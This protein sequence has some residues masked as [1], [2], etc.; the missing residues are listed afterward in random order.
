[1]SFL[2]VDVDLAKKSYYAATVQRT[3]S[4]SKLQ[5]SVSCD[6]AVED[7]GLAGLSAAIELTDRGYSV[8]V[9]E[10]KKVGWGAS[11]RNGGQALEALACDQ[12]TIEAQL[13]MIEAR[14]IWAM[15]SEA[16]ALIQERCHRFE[17]ECDWQSGYLSL[18]VNA[19]KANSVREWQHHIQ[20]EYPFKTQWTAQADLPGWNAS[21]P[22]HSGVFDTTSGHLN[23]LKYSLG[24]ARAAA[25]LGVKI[26]RHSTV[27]VL[28]QGE[29]VRLKTE[30]GE[31]RAFHV[32]LAGNVYLGNA[33]RFD[34]FSR[35]QHRSFPGGKLMRTPALVAG[36]AYH[37]LRDML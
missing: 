33:T 28:T 25:S 12:A 11:D 9:L 5:D 27:N 15:T 24:S 1:M 34:T 22:F 4:F 14:R 26:H 23:P 20:A 6:V 8:V 21:P 17:I 19:R 7:G 31:V 13:G 10:A 35:L 3:Q 29:T 37:R 32:L 2:S 18:A 30:L 36:M 16:I